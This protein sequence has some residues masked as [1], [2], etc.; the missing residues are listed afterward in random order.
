MTVLAQ[1][2]PL[3]W[4]EAFVVVAAFALIALVAARY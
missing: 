1:S 3:T 2:H 4:P